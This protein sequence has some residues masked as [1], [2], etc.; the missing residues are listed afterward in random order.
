MQRIN[1]IGTSGSGKS[2]FSRR[3][4]QTLGYPHLE[5]DAIY[6]KPN[7][8]EPDDDELFAALEQALA[9]PT[10]VLD[11]NY[12][13]TTPVKWARV[14]TVIW[15]DYSFSL[16]MY[17]A[18]TRAIK[19]SLSKKE[20]WPGTGN[21]ETFRK[22]FFSRDSIILWTMKTYRSNR[23]KYMAMLGDARY[24]HLQFV[25]IRSPKMARRYLNQISHTSERKY[26]VTDR[27]M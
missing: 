23:R 3:L 2:T 19:R 22:A 1:V 24:S 13:R 18:I 25:H 12:K 16:T 26:D 20:L 7:W 4:A 6:W 15:L 10:W 11:G 27:K 17:R 8:Q 5:L 14:D 21:V 9:A